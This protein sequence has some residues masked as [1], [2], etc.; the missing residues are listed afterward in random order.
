MAKP[1]PTNINCPNCGQPFGAIIE[2][3]LD[4]RIDPSVKERLFSGRINVITC[5]HCGYQ[6]MV[7]TPLMYHDHAKNLAIIHVPMELNLPEADREQLIGT[8]TQAIMRSLPEEANKGYLL[9]PAMALTL[10]GLIDQVLEADGITPEVIEAERHKAAFINELAGVKSAEAD[11]MLQ[12][13]IDMVDESFLEMMDM[14]ARAAGESGDSRTSLRLLN[15]RAKLLETTEVGQ[16]IKH[17]EQAVRDV[18]EEIQ[19]LNEAGLTREGFVDLL[20]RHAHNDVKLD[21]I[22]SVAGGLLDYNTFELITGRIENAETDIERKT[23]KKMRE[24]LVSIAAEIE[25]QQQ[26]VTRKASDTLLLFLQAEDVRAAVRENADLVDD[27][28]LQVLQFNMEEAAR[29]GNQEILDRLQT[30]RDEV[31]SMIE[32]SAPPEIRFINQVLSAETEEASL[33]MLR[34]RR[35]ELTPQ[36]VETMGEL[37]DQLRMAGNEPVA[38]RLER[39][40]AEAQGLL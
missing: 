18:I 39:I 11:Q 29:T 4:T 15:L 23:L 22:A 33:V 21:A 35:D 17:R 2:Q 31:I 20:C 10:Q 16:R 26:A 30:V 32:A 24:R 34:E 9:Q 13:N 25:Q 36:V 6:G 5:P 28:F 19:A 3:I 7:G 8:M 12:D 40:A 14:I 38:M 1:T 37:V 27:L